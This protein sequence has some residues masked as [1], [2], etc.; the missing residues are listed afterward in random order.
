MTA[1][2]EIHKSQQIRCH[3]IFESLV[4]STGIILWRFIVDNVV[5]NYVPL[6][7]RLRATIAFKYAVSNR[8][9]LR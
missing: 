3:R 2:N 1:I 6:K 7:C 4:L 8:R 9:G 5:T